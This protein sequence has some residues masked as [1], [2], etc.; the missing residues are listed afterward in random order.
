MNSLRKLSALFLLLIPMW[1]LNAQDIITKKNAE[2]IK[3]KVIEVGKD[4]VKYKR[5]GNETGPTYT[6]PI[7]DIFM[8]KYENGEK[9]VFDGETTAKPTTTS[10][11]TQQTAQSQ[12]ATRSTAA[13]RNVNIEN[14]AEPGKIRKGFVG[15]AIGGA[16]L[17]KDYSDVESGGFQFNVNFG[18]L[19]SK[20][21]GITSSFFLT[22]FASTYNS[23]A[24]IGL[25]GFT[26]GPLISFAIPSGK[27]EFDIRPTIGIGFLSL[28]ND[29]DSYAEGE[30]CFVLG[31]GGG[32]RWNVGKRISLVGNLDY[33]NGTIKYDRVNLSGED[34]LSSM[35]FTFGVNFR[36]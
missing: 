23:D 3:A 33:Y 27:V 4:E 29:G 2:E 35:G 1:S 11:S 36:F 16:A 7:A 22:S 34:D 14:T 28:V 21:I 25:Y 19:F 12:V 6:L 20:H 31:V 5:H 24:S 30:S 13:E 15:L 32:V 8:I 17:S 26:A 18:Y 9:D 10:A